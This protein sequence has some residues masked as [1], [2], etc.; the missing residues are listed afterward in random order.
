V[1]GE[2][3]TTRYNEKRKDITKQSPLVSRLFIRQMDVLMEIIS[4]EYS[5]GWRTTSKKEVLR[6][7]G[8]M[9]KAVDE[10]V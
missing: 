7:V 2:T 8:E 10:M 5:S 4:D 6:R 9:L 1:K 3:T